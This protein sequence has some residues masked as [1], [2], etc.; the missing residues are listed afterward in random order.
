MEIDYFFLF[1]I[2]IS[3]IN[4]FELHSNQH[5][6][7]CVISLLCVCTNV[8]VCVGFDWR[9]CSS[10][11]KDFSIGGLVNVFLFRRR[12][13][14]D[15]ISTELTDRLFDRLNG[16][17]HQLEMKE[18]KE[19]REEKGGMKKRARSYNH[20][21]GRLKWKKKRITSWSP[22]LR[23]GLENHHTRTHRDA[24]SH[25]QFGWHGY[26][27]FV[28][29]AKLAKEKDGHTQVWRKREGKSDRWRTVLAQQQDAE[30][31][32]CS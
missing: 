15:E 19:K 20:E 5:E 3:Q 13:A 26:N 1:C 4:Q 31:E 22:S 24:H 8:C 25:I 23:I 6:R 27:D 12:G 21:Y 16:T 11:L 30:T 7:L 17:D 18:C 10:L 2:R 14:D 9:V 29:G 28:N 32:T